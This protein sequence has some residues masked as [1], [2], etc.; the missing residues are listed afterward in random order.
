MPEI[1]ECYSIA[2]VLNKE[3]SGSL[4]EVKTS[5]KFKTHVLK[6]NINPSKLIGAK[7]LKIKAYGKSIWFYFQQDKTFYILVSQLGMSGSWF[8]NDYM[9]ERGH[10]HL[11]LKI[12]FDWVRY[13]D[14]RMF[15]KV[16]IFSGENLEELV[17]R[18]ISVKKWGIDP[19]SKSIDEIKK[20]LDKVCKGEKSI[21]EKLL[22]QNVI[23]GIGNYLASEVLFDAKIIPTKS[24]GKLSSNQK[25]SL[26]KSIKKWVMLAKDSGG[27]SF[28]G[29]YILP[30]GSLGDLSDKVKVYQKE[31]EN[32]SKCSKNKIKKVFMGGRSAFFCDKC[33]K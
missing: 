24:S 15:G 21:K 10:F 11:S 13:S 3:I 14:P 26:S 12:G 7:L 6:G 32:C 29:G 23:F 9:T 27:F 8:L 28:A 2:Q 16:N 20:A 19:V 31:G 5:S 30:D 33:Q 4:T 22:E 18:I 17:Q 1:G 25:D